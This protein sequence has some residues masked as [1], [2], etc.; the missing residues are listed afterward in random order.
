MNPTGLAILEHLRTGVRP[1][2]GQAQWDAYVDALED[3]AG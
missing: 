2:S 1:P 3:A